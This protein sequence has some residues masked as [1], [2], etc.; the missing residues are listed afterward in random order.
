MVRRLP[1]EEWQR[2]P[3]QNS[4]M[5]RAIAI[6]RATVGSANLYSSVVI[7]EPGGRTRVHHHGPCET[8]IFV[9]AGRARFTFGP[10]GVEDTVEAEADDIVFI[11]A[12]EP[13]V[14]ENA[15]TTER[16]VVLVTRN[17]PSGYN[18]YLDDGPADAPA[19]VSPPDR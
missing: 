19:E 4:G 7:T 11:P 12:H 13:H 16:L 18:V 10:T 1:P 5:E 9:M 2:E 17:C 15:S 3:G 8:S 14:E 6:S